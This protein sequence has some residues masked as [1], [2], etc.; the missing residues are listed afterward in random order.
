M[1]IIVYNNSPCIILD[2]YTIVTGEKEPFKEFE[3]YYQIYY[4]NK[5]I[6]IDTYGEKCDYNPKYYGKY[7]IK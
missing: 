2:E 1:E 5:K 3:D 7:I 4:N 6:W